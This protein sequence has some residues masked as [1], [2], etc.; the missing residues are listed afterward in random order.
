MIQL[1]KVPNL[2]RHVLLE[3]PTLCRWKQTYDLKCWGLRQPLSENSCVF[4]QRGV[5]DIVW[6]KLTV[7]HKLVRIQCQA[8][9]LHCITVNWRHWHDKLKT[10]CQSLAWLLLL[11][12]FDS[13][14]KPFEMANRRNDSVVKGSKSHQTCSGCTLYPLTVNRDFWPWILR[15]QRTFLWVFMFFTH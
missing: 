3:L 7:F 1:L 6:W 14:E 10:Y 15:P 4:S 13:I 2:I 11:D 8:S 9:D 12:L 5:L